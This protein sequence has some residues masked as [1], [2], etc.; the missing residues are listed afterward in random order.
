MI[1]YLASRPLFF[2]PGREWRYGPSVDI[3]GYILQ[4]ITGRFLDDFLEE[5][6][7]APLGMVDTGYTLP[8]EKIGRLVNNHKVLETRKLVGVDLLGTYNV[9][10]PVFLGG[11][12]G[13]MLS[14]AKD[15]WRFCQMI[16]NGG[17]FEG[18]R[19]LR[20]STVEMM[21]TNALEPGVRPTLHGRKLE[22]VGFGLGYGIIEEPVKSRSKLAPGSYFWLGLYGTWFSID[23]VNDIIVIGLVNNVNGIGSFLAREQAV[24]LLYGAMNDNSR[25]TD[26]ES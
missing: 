15:Y 4:K 11:G 23:P 3:L 13:L 9:S 19:Y 10:R 7:F 24:R 26:P 18:K 8:E 20:A 2:Q 6:I 14:T 16:R 22:G 17:E 12:G 21:H 25:K 5:R 1:D